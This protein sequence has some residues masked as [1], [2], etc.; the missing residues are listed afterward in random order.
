MRI[1]LFVASFLV[2]WGCTGVPES[3]SVGAS[4]GLPEQL[5][6]VKM[7]RDGETEREVVFWSLK[8]VRHLAELEGFM[9]NMAQKV[10]DSVRVETVTKEGVPYNL[11]LHYDGNELIIKRSGREEE[12][13]DQIIVSSRYSE[14]YEGA[15]I[16][17]WAV[18]GEEDGR[19]KLV[20]QI[21]P[22]LLAHHEVY[23][24]ND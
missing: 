13:F 14:H 10:K 19:R 5:A 6:D 24:M 20:L 23:V 7:E 11:D 9:D 1:F 22:D 8:E 18:D 15:F 4:E 2:L 12:R 17:Y 16:E 3:Q 21:H